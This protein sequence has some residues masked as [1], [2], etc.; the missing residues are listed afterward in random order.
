MGGSDGNSG[1]ALGKLADSLENRLILLLMAALLGIG[2]NQ[3]LVKTKPETVRPDPW[4]GTDAAQQEARILERLELRLLPHDNHL[5]KA[6]S[7]WTL[8]YAM[9]QD[10]AVLRDHVERMER[11]LERLNSGE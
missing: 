6:E 8:I 11:Q 3:V 2:G 4:T 7:G 1:G 9:R 10:I 5:A